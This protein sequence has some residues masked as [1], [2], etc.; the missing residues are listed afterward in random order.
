[1]LLILVN[2]L[3]GDTILLHVKLYEIIY[4][5]G[6]PGECYYHLEM[7]FQANNFSHFSA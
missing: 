2:A 5:T 7:N 4:P 3:T 6:Q 1:M